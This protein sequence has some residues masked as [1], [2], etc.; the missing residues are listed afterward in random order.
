M[1]G[2]WGQRLKARCW[3]ALVVLVLLLIGLF[4]LRG[5][6]RVAAGTGYF[7]VGVGSGGVRRTKRYAP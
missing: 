7:A 5:V 2:H 6:E 1:G 3:D 4:L